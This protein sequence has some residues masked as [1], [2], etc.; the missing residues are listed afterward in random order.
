MCLREKTMRELLRFFIFK[1]LVIEEI[2]KWTNI[3]E[4]P[5]ENWSVN[6]AVRSRDVVLKGIV[7]STEKLF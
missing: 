1:V 3:L 5:A 4:N 7:I 2:P 6:T